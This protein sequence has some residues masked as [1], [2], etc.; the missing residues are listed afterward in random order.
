M[1]SNMPQIKKLYILDQ[2]ETEY[3]DWSD[4]QSIKK[5]IKRRRERVKA[6]R[7]LIKENKIKTPGDLF[8]AAMIFHHSG[9]LEEY[10][11]AVTLSYI[12]MTKGSKN[13]RWLYARALDRFL[14]EISLPQKFGTQFEKISGKW[15]IC[16]Y[17]KTTTDAERRKF[18]VPT[19]GHQIKVRARELDKEDEK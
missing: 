16:A 13:G 9:R 11:L 5:L 7:R 4:S 3:T 8:R 14:L 19:L 1:G 15:H 6:I 18:L 12:S 10:G 2:S 17:D